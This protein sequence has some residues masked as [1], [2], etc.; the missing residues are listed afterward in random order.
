MGADRTPAAQAAKP[1]GRTRAAP[2][3][4]S[5][6]AEWDFGDSAFRR[7]LE[8]LAG[9]LSLVADVPAA[10]SALGTGWPVGAGPA[11]PRGRRAG[12]GRP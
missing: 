3:R 9:P 8:R 11:S 12:A 5:G 7:P 2:V 6:R 4:G 1:G 10:L